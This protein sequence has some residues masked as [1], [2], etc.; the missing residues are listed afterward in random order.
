MERPRPIALCQINTTP[1]DIP[2]NVLRIREAVTAAAALGAQICVLPELSL[3][4]YS[5]R[6]LLFREGFIA[7]ADEALT[8]LAADL[9]DVAVLVGTVRRRTGPGRPFANTAA[10]LEGGAVHRLHDKCLLPDYDVFDEARYFEGGEPGQPTS[11]R[12]VR[13]GVTI[14]EDLWVEAQGAE[15]PRYAKD[16]AK[17]LV[18]AGAEVIVNLSASPYHVGKP[19]EREALIARAASRLGVP[20]LLTNLWG[21]NDEIVFDGSSCA[22]DPSGTITHRAARFSDDIVLV[23]VPGSER[24]AAPAHIEPTEEMRR[25][26]VCG[27]R[28]YAHKCGF[29]S[30]VLGLSGGVDSA[31]SACLVV[32]AL[33]EDNVTGLALPSPFSSAGSVEDARALADMLGIP[34]HLVPIE[35]AYKELVS[36]AKGVV[37]EGPFGVMEENLQARIRGALLMAVSNRMGHLLVT[38]GNKSEL[39]VGYC[40]LY[41]DMC[42]GLAA[43]SDVF[44][45]DV[46]RLAKLY[47]AEGKLPESSITKPPS[48]ELRPDQ[49]DEDSLPPYGLLDRI[50]ELHVD[51]GAGPRTIAE[52]VPE[53]DEETVRR[54]LAL[55]ARAEYKRQQAAPGIRVSPKAF[56][57]GRRVPIVAATLAYLDEGRVEDSQ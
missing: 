4:G 3:V 51:D 29:N 8:A 17:L 44:K 19:A 6:D 26:L 40:T 43:I 32:E 36:R 9:P 42:G 46:Y 7:A 55:V 21:G 12:G 1:G 35:H 50:L 25:A 38:T 45:T 54:M 14:C 11:I 2:G 27:I 5:P 52:R 56:G 13:V 47:Q 16:P 31:V 28:D 33:G 10:L 24:A 41:G 37:G 30:A 18:D 20:V 39:A 49:K 34:L 53:V 15:V 48:A 22:A 23:Q 57:I